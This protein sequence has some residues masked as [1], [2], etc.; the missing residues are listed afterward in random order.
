MNRIS[1]INQVKYNK[2]IYLLYN[3]VGGW[4]ISVLKF[5]LRTDDKMIV[6]TSFGGRKFD[7]S[8]KVV[9]DAML[10]DKRFDECHLV[11]AFIHPENFDLVKGE[12]VRIDT[13]SYYK[14]L[15]KARIWVTNSSMTR[16]LSFTGIN[17][18]ELNTWHGSAIKRMGSDINKDNTSFKI[19]KK[20]QVNNRVM[21]AQGQYDVDV[22]SNAFRR[23]IESFRIIGLP[24]ND[25]LVHRCKEEVSLVK[26]KLG[27]SIDKTVILYA[28]TFREYEKDD[29]YNCVL[30]PPL[31]LKKWKAKLGNN[32]VLL[33]RA[34]YEVVKVMGV[35]D[36]GFVKD[37]SSYPNLNELM[38]VSD[39][40]ISD[41]SSIFFDYAIQGKPMLCFAYDYD[42]Y[43]KERGMYFD[44]RKELECM[45]MDT[46]DSVIREI[47]NMD[48]EE[49]SSISRRFREKYVTCY[50]SA[51]KR[52]LDLIYEKIINQ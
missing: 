47:Q 2:T 46:E 38:I 32:Y 27:I 34:H 19:K 20:G 13:F 6:F 15:L 40:L 48:I 36:D 25:A 43:Q 8:P 45:D 35:K 26:E 28:P 44:I 21:L 3:Y 11:W 31:D 29:N 5:F 17:S 14:K 49:R 22:F 7:D 42:R 33:F 39:M 37:V 16:G 41:Y 9:Y 52:S 51:T 50:G 23:P 4:I 1:L 24:R 30:T 18:F 12:K 10:L